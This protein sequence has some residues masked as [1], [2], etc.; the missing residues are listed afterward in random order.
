RVVDGNVQVHSTLA[1]SLDFEN[2]SLSEIV[3]AL[4]ENYDAQIV[5]APDVNSDIKTRV[6]FDKKLSIV[7]A[8]Q[9]LCEI[10][11]LKY[12]FESNKIVLQK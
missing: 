11:N 6:S 1:P 2:R 8:I 5:M 12:T 10:N 3:R 4:S 7:E 9:L